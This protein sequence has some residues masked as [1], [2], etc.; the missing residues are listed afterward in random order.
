MKLLTITLTAALLA[1]PAVHAACTTDEVNAKAEQLAQR[2]N[3]LTE[4]NPQR[5]KEINEEIHQ[6]E[7]KRTADQLG[8][9]CEAYDKRLQQIEEAEREADIPPADTQR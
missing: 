9:E 6:M 1:S 3:Q 2:I 5:A 7:A 4:S 8:D